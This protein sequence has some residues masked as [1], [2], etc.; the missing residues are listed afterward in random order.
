MV[1]PPNAHAYCLLLGCRSLVALVAVVVGTA[2]GSEPQRPNIVLILADDLG[3]GDLGCYG[4]QKNHTP[5]LDRLAREGLRFSDF[6]SNGPMCSPTRAAL[7]IGRYQHRVDIESAI[8]TDG[9]KGLPLRERTLAEVLH[10]A[11]YATA[12]FGKWHLGKRPE[13][14]PRRHGFDEFR[15]LLCGCGDYFSHVNRHGV[16][17]WWHNETPVEE[18]G[19][20]TSLVT[21]NAVRFIES[22]QEEPFFL[23]VAHLA[24]HFPWMTPHDR[25][26]RQPGGSYLDVEAGPKSKLGPHTPEDVGN[27]VT[28]MIEELD[29][30]VGRIIDTLGKSSL[31]RRTL[32]VFTS[33]NGGYLR[34]PG[35]WN[36]I[37]SNGPLRGQKC[38][39]FE[40]GHRVPTIAWW[41][42]RI[43][44]GTSTDET[45]ITMD[46]F[47]TCLELAGV[48]SP[49]PSGSLALDGV[50]LGRLLL[51]GE[52]LPERTLFWRIHGQK[53]ARR[54]P[55]KFVSIPRQP[56]QLYNLSDDIGE[57]RNL[58]AKRPEVVDVLSAGL[59]DWEEMVA[60]DRE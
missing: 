50:S 10:E 22:H 17:D 35:G 34:Y 20:T 21:E 15:G 54:G 27:A 33:D 55:W 8:S 38:D 6:H 57:T 47:P 46:L 3:Y 45:A 31:D 25:G 59:A 58:A 60:A 16:A 56:P 53:A 29:G 24:I 23:Y 36:E 2:P 49:D 43:K 26:F 44:P 30:S 42:G 32:V 1:A 13:F 11:G 40:G 52:P 41:P 37:S 51:H 48:E 9:E 7:L 5:N 39:V 14:L 4:N 19:Y 28:R 12:V 18:Q